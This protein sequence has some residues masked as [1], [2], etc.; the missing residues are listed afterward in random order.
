MTIERKPT[1]KSPTIELHDS[2]SILAEINSTMFT[3]RAIPA[4]GLA[5][6]SVFASQPLFAALNLY[7]SFNYTAPP[8]PNDLNGESG[9]RRLL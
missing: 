4:V 5:M 7:E 6:V 8:P 9:L 2:V 1:D 3:R